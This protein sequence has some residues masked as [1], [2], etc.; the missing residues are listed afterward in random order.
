MMKLASVYKYASGTR[1]NT[2]HIFSLELPERVAVTLTPS[3]HTDFQWL[4]FRE[5]AERVFSWTNREAILK[6]KK[7]LL[8]LSRASGRG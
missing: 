3:E 5:A 4:T 1:E 7:H 6:I 8:P 2:E